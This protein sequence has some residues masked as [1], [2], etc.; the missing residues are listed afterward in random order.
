MLR[1]GPR[2]DGTAAVQASSEVDDQAA[3]VGAVTSR[4]RRY[5]R[6]VVQIAQV[7][8]LADLLVA[9]LLGDRTLLL[10]LAQILE[11]LLADH[12][13]A[14]QAMWV[15]VPGSTHAGHRQRLALRAGV[16]ERRRA[17]VRAAVLDGLADDDPHGTIR[18]LR[19]W[20]LESLPERCG[21]LLAT[22]HMEE[23]RFVHRAPESVGHLAQMSASGG[24]RDLHRL[25]TI[26][27][28]AVEL[29]RPTVVA[30]LHLVR[31]Y[32]R[33]HMDVE[34]HLDR[35]V[36]RRV[37]VEVL[38]GLAVG[39]EWTQLHAARAKNVVPPGCTHPASGTADVSREGEKARSIATSLYRHIHLPL[40]LPSLPAPAH[41][42]WCSCVC[43]FMTTTWAW[44]SS[45]G[46]H[47]VSCR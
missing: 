32:G 39:D 3:L 25:K 29:G 36:S 21:D 34:V 16:H 26:V 46:C 45:S 20:V 28:L 47:H 8:L 7:V 22:K 44:C 11:L 15:A 41:V 35:S 9:L 19:R 40:P 23:R 4:G 18:K 1:A 42:A 5:I 33:A 30:R 2:F 10:L 27:Q 13:L 43:R 14:Q 6:M 17:R 12:L 37:H 24:E 31:V 38:R